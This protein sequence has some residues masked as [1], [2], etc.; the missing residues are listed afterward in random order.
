MIGAFILTD[1]R[2]TYFAGTATFFVLCQSFKFDNQSLEH[3]PRLKCYSHLRHERK[4]ATV[5]VMATPLK[6]LIEDFAKSESFDA[7]D[8]LPASHELR[9]FKSSSEWKRKAHPATVH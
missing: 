4:S 2:S 5:T 3:L 7:I 8:A 1:A 9:S 6:A